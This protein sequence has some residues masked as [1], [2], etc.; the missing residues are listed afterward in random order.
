MVGEETEQ[1]Q[2]FSEHLRPTKSKYA[3]AS[4]SNDSI[5]IASDLGCSR[6]TGLVQPPSTL[7][8]ELPE[9][10]KQPSSLQRKYLTLRAVTEIKQVLIILA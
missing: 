3:F 2:K 5:N 4:C 6:V 7:P 10:T 1:T 9:F 8:K